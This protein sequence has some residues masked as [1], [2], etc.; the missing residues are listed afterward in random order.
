MPRNNQIMAKLVRVDDKTYSQLQRVAGKIQTGSGRRTSLCEAIR[1]LLAGG[2]L[3]LP[4][5]EKAAKAAKPKAKAKKRVKR[6]KRRTERGLVPY[7]HR[8][9]IH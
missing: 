4:Q 8:R 6:N 3:G 7:F 1:R 9:E 5:E 2:K